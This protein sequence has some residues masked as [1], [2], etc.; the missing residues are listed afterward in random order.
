MNAPDIE[1]E[2]SGV[3]DGLDLSVR[4]G[5]PKE[6]LFLTD[7]HPR[8]TWDG[9]PGLAGTGNSWLSIHDYFRASTDKISEGLL[10]LREDAMLTPDGV[11]SFRRHAGGLLD[12]LDS[13]HRIEDHHYFP[14]FQRAE[15]RLL[16][17]FEIMD[18]DHHVIHR[19]IAE[20]AGTAREFLTRVGQVEGHLNSDARFAADEMADV[21]DRFGRILR[22]HLADEEDLVIP[23]II[24]R[25]HSDPEFSDFKCAT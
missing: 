14:I 16:R 6:F 22:Q 12:G 25:A 23:L 5:L 10:K 15:P 2:G 20:F 1:N 19:A 17:A 11:S 18:D 7:R 21:V 24:E 4:T 8:K 13:H 3:V 9:E